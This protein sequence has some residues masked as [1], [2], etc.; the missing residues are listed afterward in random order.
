[1]RTESFGGLAVTYKCNL[2][3]LD[4]M[5]DMI[6]DIRAKNTKNYGLINNVGIVIPKSWDELTYSNLF[7]DY[8][9]KLLVMIL[10]PKDHLCCNNSI[11]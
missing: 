9:S 6:N 4:N 5:N 10:S 7:E 1:M 2:T 3:N 11:S 8:G